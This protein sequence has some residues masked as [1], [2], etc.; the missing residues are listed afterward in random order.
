MEIIS[1][2]PL[3]L[4]IEDF[5]SNEECEHVI[6]I[7]KDKLNKAKTC[8]YS[9]E[10]EKRINSSD[11]IGRT[12]KNC[13]IKYK[14][15]EIIDNIYKKASKLLRCEI[16]YFESLQVINYQKNEEYKYHY[17]GWNKNEKEKYEKYCTKNGNRIFTLLLYLNDVEEG[18]ETGF[19]KFDKEIKIKP[20]KRS[21]LLFKS[22]NNDGTLNMK[23][24]HAGLPVIE[25]EKWACNLWLRDKKL[26]EIKKPNDLP[27][28][29]LDYINNNSS[30]E[31]IDFNYIDN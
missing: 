7:S 12:N 8:F 22:I 13:W 21:A 1:T 31:E 29:D 4:T 11:Y 5:L 3:I 28:L 25:G 20:K 26:F 19:N 15:D 10:D 14:T 18:G 17:D 27:D 9:D 2:E 23:S 24:C 16:N 6:N 30:D